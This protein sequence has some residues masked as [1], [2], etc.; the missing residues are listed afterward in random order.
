MRTQVIDQSDV[1]KAI[2]ICG[3]IK[4][5]DPTGVRSVSNMISRIN[6]RDFIALC[7]Y[8]VSKLCAN[9]VDITA[10]KHRLYCFCRCDIQKCTLEK[11]KYG[12][13]PVSTSNVQ[14]KWWRLIKFF[15]AKTS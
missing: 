4:A 9:A 7:R 12:S 6:K 11:Q 3:K 13:T 10:L 8:E 2:E 1:D 5:L 15:M 14:H